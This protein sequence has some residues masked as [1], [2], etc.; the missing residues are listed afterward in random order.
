MPIVSIEVSSGKFLQE[1]R[2]RRAAFGKTVAYRITVPENLSYWYFLEFGTAGRQDSSAPY[3][4]AIAPGGTYPIEPVNGPQSLHWTD[5]SGEHF[6]F[7]VDHPGIRPRL[8]YRGVR[9]DILSATAFFIGQGFLNSGV[10]LSSLR[11]SML[12]EAMPY[13]IEEMAQAFDSASPALSG[14]VSS[15]FALG[16]EIIQ[17]K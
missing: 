16:A 5:G 6:A 9:D 3:K 13:A 4:T 11:Q 15:D 8:V 12:A 17:T 7:H 14:S 2:S 10:R 1:L